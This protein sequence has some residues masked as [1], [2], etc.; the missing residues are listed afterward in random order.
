MRS[1]S[2]ICCSL[3][4]ALLS[5]RLLVF[6]CLKNQFQATLNHALQAFCGKVAD[7]V[8]EMLTNLWSVLQAAMEPHTLST[9]VCHTPYRNNFDGLVNQTSTQK[10][11]N[12]FLS[13]RIGFNVKGFFRHK[14][15][16]LIVWRNNAHNVTT[17][18]HNRILLF[19]SPSKFS[20]EK[21]YGYTPSCSLQHMSFT[22]LAG[23]NSLPLK[24]KLAKICKIITNF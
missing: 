12:L 17:T 7:F 16:E 19:G 22:Q 23:W 3:S 2:C 11:R 8:S 1:H 15:I 9:L 20:Q 6:K 18:I 5:I 4:T 13:F 14:T 24:L 21:S 10:A